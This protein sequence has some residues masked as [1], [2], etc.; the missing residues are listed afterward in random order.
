MAKVPVYTE[1]AG[2]WEASFMAGW[3]YDIAMVLENHITF[4]LKLISHIPFDP[5]FRNPSWI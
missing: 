1:D 2:Q 4:F 5:R 3:E